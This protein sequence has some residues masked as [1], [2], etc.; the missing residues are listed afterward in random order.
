MW[1]TKTQLIS[2]LILNISQSINEWKNK[3]R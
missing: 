3:W 1:T 2:L